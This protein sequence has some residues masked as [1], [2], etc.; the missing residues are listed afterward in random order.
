[1][2]DLGEDDEILNTLEFDTIVD[3]QNPTIQMNSG[4][5]ILNGDNKLLGFAKGNRFNGLLICQ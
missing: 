1:M 4:T 2:L 5:L 3:T